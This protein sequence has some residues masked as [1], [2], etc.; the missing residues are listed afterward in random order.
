MT[1]A[2][3]RDTAGVIAPPP[4]IYGA[5]LLIAMMLNILLPVGEFPSSL[6]LLGLLLLV[7]S[8]I[9]GPWALILM[10]RKGVNPEP[11]HPTSALVTTGIFRYTRN[12]IYMTFTL[13][14]AGFGLLFSNL[15]ALLLLI[16][17]LIIIHYGV[18]VREERYLAR[19]F[20]DNYRQYKA[21]VRRWI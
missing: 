13:F 18:I 14:V 19:K 4:L 5:G 11:N 15:W 21:S 2:H 8:F 20:G 16:L 1:D 3:E 7:L 6:R 17:I 9:P 10:L 12:P